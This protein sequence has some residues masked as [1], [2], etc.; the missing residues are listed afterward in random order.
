MREYVRFDPNIMR[1]L[2]YY[3]G[4]VF[5]AFDRTGGVRRA[6][7]G[8]GRYD[9]LLA[10]V[11]GDPLSGVGFA[12]GDVVIGIILSE[13]GL[14]P[15]FVP[16]PS[17][18]LVTIFDQ[19]LWLTSYALAAELRGAGLN[20]TT[21]PEP[22]KLP[23]QFKYADKMGMRAVV[24]VGP[25]EVAA[26]KATVKDLRSGTQQVVARADVPQVIRKI[27]ESV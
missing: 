19:S 13:A 5:E 12:M 16:S 14:V 26:G 11:G 8:G 21:Y 24:V 17:P 2:D 10:D 25:D 20:V 15:P 23:K 27:L 6:I 1:G 3:T 4:T 9:N 22:A 7:F 18:V